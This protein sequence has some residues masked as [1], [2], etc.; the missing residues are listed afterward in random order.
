MT[1]HFKV[2]WPF[3]T[4]FMLKPTVGM[5]LSGVLAIEIRDEFAQL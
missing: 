1:Y 2:T 4:L 3:C 5:E